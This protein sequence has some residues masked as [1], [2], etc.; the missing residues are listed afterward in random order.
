MIENKLNT[1]TS[2]QC[3]AIFNPTFL[4][5]CNKSIDISPWVGS[6]LKSIPTTYSEYFS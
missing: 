6:P 1:L 5:R 2:A 3:A 4:A